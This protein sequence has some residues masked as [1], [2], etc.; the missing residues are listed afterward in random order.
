MAITITDQTCHAQCGLARRSWLRALVKLGVPHAHVGRRTVCL[1]SDW[2]AAIGRQ[3]G[4]TLKHE[5]LTDAEV[6]ARAT[7]G[8]K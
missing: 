1:A 8:S 2:V 3:T 5:A 6:I 4:S 7:G